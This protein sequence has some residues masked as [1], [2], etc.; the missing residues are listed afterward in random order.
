MTLNLAASLYLISG[1]LF[2]LAL[3]GLSSPNT[4]I[5]GNLFGILGMA[6][7]I[8]V[9]F[10][11]IDILFNGFVFII[12]ALAIG[13][14]IGAII[15]YRISMTAMPQLVAGFHSLV[16]LAAV[17]V[18][19][20]AFYNPEAFELG[21]LNNIKKASLVEMS[22]G[23]SIGAITFTGSIIAFLKLQGLMSGSPIT[24]KGQHFVNLLI[25]IGIAYLIFYITINQSNHIFWILIISSFLI[26]ILL[27]IPI[28]GADMPVVISMLNSYSGWA[29]A[30]IGFTLENTALI[31]TGAL[32][33]SSGAILSYIMCKGMN[34][35]FF[36]V[37]LGGFGG[38]NP[39]LEKDKDRKPVKSGNAEDAA[40]LMKNASS[41]IIVPGYGMAV[42]QPQLPSTSMKQE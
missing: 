10:L 22:I 26:G 38:T 8:S 21:T 41:V 25:G 36:N 24:Y 32:V 18:A 29:A 9:T 34:R 35:S 39:I 15:A 40:F 6:L 12:C 20:S 17:L 11:S 27:I 1:V 23:G 7:A 3:R 16:G 13:G 14:S 19:L 42:A 37:I 4:S 31:I 5:R 2:I 33:G 28:G 30:G